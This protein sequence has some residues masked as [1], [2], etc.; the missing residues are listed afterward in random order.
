MSR[1]G[2]NGHLEVLDRTECVQ[3]LAGQGV[4]RVAG[5]V[6]G[7]PVI[8]PVNYAVVGDAVLVRARRGG[9]LDRITCDTVV[10]FEVDG[11]DSIYHE[12]WSVLV[13]GR[14]AHVTDPAE[15]DAL[16]SLRLLSWA[17]EGRDLFIRI[18]LDDVT[19]RRIHHLEP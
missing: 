14:S 11:S 5:T 12:G 15:L 10:A 7:R 17:G 8:L 3:F 1:S 9:D 4:G 2:S 19:G 16:R 18:V 6:E 13:V